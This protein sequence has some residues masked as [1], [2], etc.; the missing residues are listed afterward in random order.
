MEKFKEEFILI[1][2]LIEENDDFLLAVHE[3]PDGDALGSMIAVFSVLSEIYDKQVVMFSKDPVP[4]NLRFL[5]HSEG[6]VQKDIE[7]SPNILFGFDYGD[8]ARLGLKK[9][10]LNKSVIVT[11]DHHPY[12]KQEGDIMVIDEEAS[13]TCEVIYDFF[14]QAKYTISA[15]MATALLTGIFTDTGGFSH[16]NTS[17]KTMRVVGDLLHCGAS[18]PKIYKHTF[19]SKSP[20]AMKVWGHVLRNTMRDEE[21]GMAF[22]C[23]KYDE[24]MILTTNKEDFDGIANTM[25]MP[26]DVKFS[27]LLLEYEPGVLKGSLRSE[28]F[29]G[30]DV[31]AIAR[32]LGGGGHKYAAGFETTGDNIDNVIKLVREIAGEMV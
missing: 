1:S 16:I 4:D 11:F 19:C 5:P 14:V 7:L 29:K 8:F 3:Y 20:S 6:I 18:I 17:V 10:R 22:A 23:L 31:S 24:L 28:S 25:I 9:S 26:P 15:Q 32:S 12:L 30:V 21:T 13:S 2:N 27:L